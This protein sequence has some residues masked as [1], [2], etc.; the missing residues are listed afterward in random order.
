MKCY[1]YSRLREN[2]IEELLKEP[3]WCFP[4]P[5]KFKNLIML[6]YSFIYELNLNLGTRFPI[7]RF[8]K[9]HWHL[10][11]QH[12]RNQAAYHDYGGLQPS[13]SL[14]T[15]CLGHELPTWPALSRHGRGSP[16]GGILSG[17]TCVSVAG[18]LP[19]TA[20][21]V[22]G[23]MRLCTD[24]AS[25]RLRECW[26]IVYLLSPGFKWSWNWV[27]SRFLS[28]ACMTLEQWL[29]A[30]SISRESFQRPQHCKCK[31]TCMQKDTHTHS[32]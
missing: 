20:Q 25:M 28:L 18:T 15:V 12:S 32:F 3:R 7:H 23:I 31:N 2:I 22:P 11:S 26:E 10:H 5:F 21:T 1:F 9:N 17:Q 29:L 6:I 4:S 8:Q 30:C 19:N 27:F 24:R 14:W 13:C 16:G